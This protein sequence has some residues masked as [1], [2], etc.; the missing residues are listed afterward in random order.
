MEKRIKTTMIGSIDLIEKKFSD[1]IDSSEDFKQ[2]F[3]ELRKEI[4]DLGNS[5]IRACKRD[6][7]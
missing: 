1:L 4:L 6:K 7:E 2:R 3:Q 5:Q